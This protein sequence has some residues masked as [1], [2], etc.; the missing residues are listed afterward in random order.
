ML[1]LVESVH[2]AATTWLPGVSGR[3]TTP[4]GTEAFLCRTGWPIRCENA[5]DEV[6]KSKTAIKV[7]FKVFLSGYD[8]LNFVRIGTLIARGVRGC[9]RAIHDP[10]Q[11][12]GVLNLSA[13]RKPSFECVGT[14]RLLPAIRR[15][16]HNVRAVRLLPCR[17]NL[18][19][20][21]WL[22]HKPSC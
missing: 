20:R 6:S 8:C 1:P 9:H 3:T 14:A 16:V 11:S 2:V 13:L 10:A 15:V 18:P 17:C 4:G 22:V 21:Q 12:A 19:R 7:D 5:S